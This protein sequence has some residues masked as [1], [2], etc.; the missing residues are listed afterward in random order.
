MTFPE[1]ISKV[2]RV[3]KAHSFFLFI[4]EAKARKK[5][6][7]LH[8]TILLRTDY[9]EAHSLGKS[10]CYLL[11][12]PRARQYHVCCLPSSCLTLESQ[13]CI[14]SVICSCQPVAFGY[15]YIT[16]RSPLLYVSPNYNPPPAGITGAEFDAQ[17]L[18]SAEEVRVD[19]VRLPHTTAIRLPGWVTISTP[20][21]RRTAGKEATFHPQITKP[22]HSP[23][24]RTTFVRMAHWVL[25]TWS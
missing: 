2:P 9:T 3:H 11:S 20:S 5:I 7:R 14:L 12:K 10:P 16:Q 23:T 18:N 17:S 22:P 24:H 25:Q 19:I 1:L 15:P 8:I 6:L 21:L 4:R 13:D